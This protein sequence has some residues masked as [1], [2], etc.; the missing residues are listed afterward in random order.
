M[1]ISTKLAIF[2]NR[3][4]GGRWEKGKGKRLFPLPI[5]PRSLSFSSLL[6]PYNIK[7]PLRKREVYPEYF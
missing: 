3:K 1:G 7:G 6:P 2:E 4:R 5:V